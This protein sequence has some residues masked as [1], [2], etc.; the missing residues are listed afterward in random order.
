MQSLALAGGGIIGNTLISRSGAGGVYTRSGAEYTGGDLI[1]PDY[2]LVIENNQY[3]PSLVLFDSSVVRHCVS[4][5]KKVNPD[6]TREPS[7]MSL[8][9]FQK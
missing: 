3:N 8:I 5:I 7:R 6:D 4:E 9:F 2:N 1:F